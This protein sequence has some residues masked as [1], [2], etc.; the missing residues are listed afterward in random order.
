MKFLIKQGE[1]IHRERNST[2]SLSSC[3]WKCPHGSRTEGPNIF[4]VPTLKL[5]TPSWRGNFFH[6]LRLSGETR[7]LPLNENECLPVQRQSPKSL[8]YRWCHSHTAVVKKDNA[9]VLEPSGTCGSGAPIRLRSEILPVSSSA[10]PCS[11]ERLW[12]QGQFGSG[13]FKN[14]NRAAC[15]HSCWR[16]LEWSPFLHSLV[17]VIW[18]SMKREASWHQAACDN[19]SLFVLLLSKTQM[20]IPGVCSENIW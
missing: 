19:T 5:L 18:F 20:L 13:C 3:H 6:S 8:V 7:D 2:K 14:I 9:K 1:E 15:S 16:Q 10:V 4:F 12:L 11:C 17:N